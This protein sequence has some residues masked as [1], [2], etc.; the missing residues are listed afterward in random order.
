VSPAD[1]VGDGFVASLS[2]P[3]GNLTGFLFT[4]GAI[5][6]KWLELLIEIAPRVKRAAIMYNPDTAPGGGSFY[7]PFFEAAAR[8]LK[9]E[10]IT[11]PVHNDSEIETGIVSLG[12]E[13]GSG[14]VAMGDPFMLAH[15]AAVILAA[16]RNN[17]P[18]ISFNAVFP[19]DGGLLSYEP[20]L[21]DMFRRAA[22]Y[23]DRILRGA[24][25]AD[26]PVQAPVKFEVVLNIKAVK[27]LGLAV[28]ANMLA[29]ANEVIE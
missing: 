24:K 9:L 3:G 2:R 22:S 15:R 13:P 1:P 5:A 25:P 28:P 19:R 21:E 20:D 7:L 10:Q 18:A 8:S 27:A 29:R 16:S 12:R 17:L 26:L 6:G 23:V 11:M 14:L 4:E